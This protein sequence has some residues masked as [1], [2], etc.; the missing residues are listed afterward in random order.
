M[1]ENPEH[2]DRPEGT[3]PGHGI[4]AGAREEIE[5][6]EGATDEERLKVLERLYK[7]LEGALES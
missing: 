3:V 7:N 1:N 4:E 5:A 6:A 2:S